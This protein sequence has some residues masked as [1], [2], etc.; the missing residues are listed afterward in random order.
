M[1][2]MVPI[3][4]EWLEDFWHNAYLVHCLALA[5]HQYMVA[6]FIISL[7]WYLYSLLVAAATNAHERVA[8]NDRNLFSPSSECEK[9]KIKL[10]AGLVSPRDSG[11]IQVPCFSPSLCSC[12]LSLLFLDLQMHHPNLCLCLHFA[13]PSVSSSFHLF[14]R[15]SIIGFS[16]HSNS[17]WS[18]LV[19]HIFFN[20]MAAPVAYGSS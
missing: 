13:F 11:K 8:S 10:S 15:T 7:C 16:A 2:T 17:R 18:H 14:T 5:S 1:C 3:S 19:I 12:S 4:H 6:V 9:A 20:F